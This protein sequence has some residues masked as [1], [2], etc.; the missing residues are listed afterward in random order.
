MLK[1]HYILNDID[2]ISLT[3]FRCFLFNLFDLMYSKNIQI[4]EVLDKHIQTIEYQLPSR[5]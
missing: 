5:N 4:L 2:F 1:S 3:P